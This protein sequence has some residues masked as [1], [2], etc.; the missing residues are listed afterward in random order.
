[1]DNRSEVRAFLT[2][3]RARIDSRQAGR[4]GLLRGEVAAL[5]GVSLEFY[6]S[7]ER[8]DLTGVSASVLDAVARALRLDDAETAHLHQLARVAGPGPAHAPRHA[9][10]AEIR[11]AIRRVLNSMTAT[12]A[13]LRNHRF[14]I[15]AAN[16]L[17]Q[18]LCAPMFAGPVRP[19]NAVRYVFLDPT[20]QQFFVDWHR[21]A[22]PAV[23]ALRDAAAR[24][25]DDH[26][27]MNLVGELSMR[28]EAFR[29]WWAAREGHVYRHATIRVR[30]P[31]V[32]EL[33]LDRELLDVPEEDL[34]IET[35][36]AEA[37]TASGDGLALLAT[38]AASSEQ[39]A[40]RFSRRD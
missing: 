37:G 28:S 15:F 13:F 8:G 39:V 27:L 30:H 16:A 1:M 2:S 24:Y 4:P 20:A 23:D 5:A 14:D 32:G 31:V 36:S 21:V 35:F 17:G 38:W 3:R 26:Q 19:L 40:I 7:L 10:A 25:P 29:A 33:E 6:S 34:T 12:P 11:P 18:A 22:R 9:G